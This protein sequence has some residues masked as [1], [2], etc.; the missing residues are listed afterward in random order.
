MMG[1]HQK[2]EASWVGSGSML[3]VGLDPDINRLPAHIPH[4][5][6]GIELFCT[7]IIDAMKFEP[8]RA[9][10]AFGSAEALCRQR[11][12]RG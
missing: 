10:S 7:T 9:I 3:C 2:L 12:V 5:H 11:R 4:T 8:S 1:F 6:A